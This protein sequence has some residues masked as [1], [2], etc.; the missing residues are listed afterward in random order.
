MSV[1]GDL[2]KMLVAHLNSMVGLP[3]VAWENK[4]FD[5][6]HGNIYLRP[7]LLA[8]E[9]Y[10]ASLGENGT[11][12]NLGIY[13]IDIFIE[14]GKGRSEAV[15]MADIIS[16]HFKRGTYLTYNGRTLRTKNVSRRVGTNNGDGW[17]QIPVIINYIAFTTARI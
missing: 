3:S 5:P 16:N 9:V 11:D 12:G 2:D 7:T 1:F 15:N 8:G 13:Q 17:Y 6:V 10:Q 14:S 4:D